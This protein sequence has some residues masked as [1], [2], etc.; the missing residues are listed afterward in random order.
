MKEDTLTVTDNRTNITYEISIENNTIINNHATN[1]GG[2]GMVNWSWGTIIN[3]I[4][5]NNN[6]YIVSFW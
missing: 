1:S 3:N 6:G 5:W 2:G 4:L